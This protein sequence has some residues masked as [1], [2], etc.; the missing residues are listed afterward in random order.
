MDVKLELINQS[1]NSGVEPHYSSAH[2]VRVK[3]VFAYASSFLYSTGH[4][5]QNSHSSL[6]YRC[7]LSLGRQCDNTKLKVQMEDISYLIGSHS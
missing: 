1:I 6:T 3:V 5:A 7:N 2:R 4:S